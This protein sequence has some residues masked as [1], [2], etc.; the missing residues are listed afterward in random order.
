MLFLSDTS[1]KESRRQIVRNTHHVIML[2][3]DNLND[4]MGVFEKKPSDE[5]KAETDKVHDEWG[6]TL[7][8][9]PNATYGEWENAIY[10][11]KRGLSPDEKDKIRKQKLTG[12]K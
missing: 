9:L 12:F 8:V 5:R 6:N 2:L 1:G 4:F 3:G 10:N 7:I 11:Y